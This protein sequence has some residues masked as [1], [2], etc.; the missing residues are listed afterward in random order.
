MYLLS[1]FWLPWNKYSCYTQ[2]LRNA[3]QLLELGRS[4]SNTQIRH[5]SLLISLSCSGIMQHSHHHWPI[6]NV[7]ITHL[8]SDWLDTFTLPHVHVHL[9]VHYQWLHVYLITAIGL[10]NLYDVSDMHSN[11]HISITLTGH[12]QD[13]DTMKDNEKGVLM[14]ARL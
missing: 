14:R 13:E 8:G 2:L 12:Y 9:L 6:L 4:V 5:R 7:Q 1:L 3:Q 11:G 10:S